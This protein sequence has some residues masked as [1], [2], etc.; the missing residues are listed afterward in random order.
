MIEKQ[1]S[2][3]FVG[4]FMRIFRVAVTVILL[5][6]PGQ[7]ASPVLAQTTIKDSC[8][9]QK[10]ALVKGSD[11]LY[12][13]SES[14]Y[15]FEY[16]ASNQISLPTANNFAAMVGQ[17]GQPA[18]QVNFDEFFNRLIKNLQAAGAEEE[19]IRGYRTL[20]QDFKRRFTDLA[21]YRVG[22]IQVQIY[23]TGIN[24]SC[25]MAG[26]KTISIET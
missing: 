12:Y 26:L 1:F 21:V 7:P 25:G 14:E 23:L 13:P 10:K 5:L 19:T 4:I 16:F 24:T 3:S 9:S 6:Q 18:S 11:R 20:R 17:Q 22:T 15:P 8:D 2:Y